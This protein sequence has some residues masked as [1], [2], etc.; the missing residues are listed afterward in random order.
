MS[1]VK[2]GV[3]LENKLM[4]IDKRAFAIHIAYNS[5]DHIANVYTARK[6][7]ITDFSFKK[8]NAHKPNNPLMNTQKRI[9]PATGE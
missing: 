5:L 8:N 7:V 9:R 4:L 6:H 3:L 1:D 2:T